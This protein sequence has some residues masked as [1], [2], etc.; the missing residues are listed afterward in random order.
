MASGGVQN[1]PLPPPPAPSCRPSD[2]PAKAPATPS[3]LFA[4][5]SP[6]ALAV[7]NGSAASDERPPKIPWSPAKG[8]TVPENDAGSADDEGEVPMVGG[9]LS[10]SFTSLTNSVGDIDWKAVVQRIG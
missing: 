9:S 10:A 8:G 1:P 7:A 3:A 6:R 2:S 5:P 4:T